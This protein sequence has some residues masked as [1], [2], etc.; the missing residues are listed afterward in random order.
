[1][2]LYTVDAALM[3]E[4]APTVIVTQSLCDVCSVDMRLVERLCGSLAPRPQIISLNPFSLDEVLADCRTVGAALGLEAGAAAAVAALE[5]RV[6]AVRRFVTSQPP[7]R[8]GSVGWMEWTEP[9]FVS[10][11]EA[12][13]A[14]RGGAWGAWGAWG[15]SLPDCR[16]VQPCAWARTNTTTNHAPPPPMSKTK[17]TKRSAPATGRRS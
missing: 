16:A 4:L 1:M 12:G 3:Q 5:A 7:L 14:K 9:I 11:R 15:V 13:G 6:A 17:Q 2:G 10:E 8:L